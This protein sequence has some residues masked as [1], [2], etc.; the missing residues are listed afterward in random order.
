[1][2]FLNQIQGFKPQQLKSTVTTVTTVDGR[3][4]EESRDKYGRI[5]SE[6]VSQGAQGFVG[7]TKLDLQIA[8]VLPGLYLSS[9]DVAADVDI[10]EQH[11][12]THILNVASMIENWFP[13]D[14]K[15]L[16]IE[17][18]DIPESDISKHFPECFK[19][20]DEALG[21][22][23]RV[24]VHCNAGVSRSATIVIAY[25]MRTERM[26]LQE[27]HSKVAGVRPCIRPNAGFQHQLKT[28][29][30]LLQSENNTSKSK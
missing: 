9:Q 19:F 15:Y 22:K 5:K 26:T 16:K 13:D 6:M 3:T 20:I 30:K 2:S 11:D 7:D 8:E 28:Y 4:L 27:A 10:L 14:F 25:I 1:M 23:G 18:L 12:I 24:L 17:I 21:S 29:E